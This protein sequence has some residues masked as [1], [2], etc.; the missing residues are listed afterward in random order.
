MCGKV[1]GAGRAVGQKFIHRKKF[2]L[3]HGASFT[4]LITKNSHQSFVGLIFKVKMHR[5][6]SRMVTN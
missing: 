5:N 4:V 3:P 6:H 2:N 1:T